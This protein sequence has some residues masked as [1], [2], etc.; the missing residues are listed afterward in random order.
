MDSQTGRWK[1][2]WFKAD[3]RELFDVPIQDSQYTIQLYF[4]RS[5]SWTNGA[6]AARS[7]TRAC[8]HA[9]TYT[10]R[11]NS[12]VTRYTHSCC[13]AR[14][15]GG[16]ETLACHGKAARK[17][18]SARLRGG[19]GGV[20]GHRPHYI[21]FPSNSPIKFRLYNNNL[22]KRAHRKPSP[23]VAHLCVKQIDAQNK[24]KQQTVFPSD[25]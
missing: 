2:L 4:P 14:N 25:Q 22:R 18:Q 16:R 8:T 24:K 6:D 3:H 19:G 10:R 13:H 23:Y 9:C 7:H 17:M 15:T 21:S 11:A 1:D 20:G 5:L 12:T